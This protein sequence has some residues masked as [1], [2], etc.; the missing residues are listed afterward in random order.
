MQAVVYFCDFNYAMWSQ[1]VR[2][3]QSVHTSF[4]LHGLALIDQWLQETKCIM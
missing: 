3:K 4:V 2:S 1:L